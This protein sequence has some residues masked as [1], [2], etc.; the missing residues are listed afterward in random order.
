V[1]AERAG[2]VA[3][4]N[5]N[6]FAEAML[7]LLNSPDV[8]ERMGENG[9]TLVRKRFQWSSVALDLE[10]A[11]RSILSGALSSVRVAKK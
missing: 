9:K 10:N 3:P 6:S 8:A 1:E 4:C 2:K 7:S 11:Y 5:G